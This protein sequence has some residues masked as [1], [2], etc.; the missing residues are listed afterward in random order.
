MEIRSN[1]RKCTLRLNRW[2]DLLLRQLGQK[3]SSEWKIYRRG[4]STQILFH[5][6]LLLHWI[7]W[8]RYNK[9][10]RCWGY[11]TEY[12]L[13]FYEYRVWMC[14]HICRRFTEICIVEKFKSKC[15]TFN[16]DRRPERTFNNIFYDG[17]VFWTSIEIR[18]SNCGIFNP[19]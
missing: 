6:H 16:G 4:H 13:A 17:C 5:Y 19:T 2:S 11:E 3:S 15:E 9:A 8:R 7:K 18:R 14:L 12:H 1:T 10:I